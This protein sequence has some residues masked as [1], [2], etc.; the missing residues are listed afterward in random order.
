MNVTIATSVSR[1]MHIARGADLTKGRRQREF[2]DRQSRS[3]RFFDLRSSFAVTF[4]GRVV[5]S[6]ICLEIN[7]YDGTFFCYKSRTS[8]VIS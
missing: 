8:K 5:D 6:L 3:L 7:R 1:W 4:Q 2:F